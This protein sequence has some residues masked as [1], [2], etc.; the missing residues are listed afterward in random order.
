MWYCSRPECSRPVRNA[1][2]YSRHNLRAFC[3]YRRALLPPAR[4][5]CGIAADLIAAGL[6]AADLCVLPWPA[7]DTGLQQQAQPARLV[8]L[9]VWQ[10]LLLARYRA[11]W[12][13]TRVWRCSDALPATRWARCSSVAVQ[14]CSCVQQ[15]Q[16][17]RLLRCPTPRCALADWQPA[18]PISARLLDRGAPAPYSC[19]A[20]SA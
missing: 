2:A 8:L 7:A 3:C 18:L 14:R 17:A 1:L 6:I 9:G 4:R 15:A 19:A 16:P 20:R 10:L 12:R 13:A 11:A 5:A